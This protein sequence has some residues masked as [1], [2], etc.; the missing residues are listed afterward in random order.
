MSKVMKIAVDDPY[1]T[2][3]RQGKM[4]KHRFPLY[5]M[6]IYK[7]FHLKGSTANSNFNFTLLNFY[8]LDLAYFH[9]LLKNSN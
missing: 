9:S 1:G 4:I 5:K 8:Q 6:L 7:L 3:E 2:V